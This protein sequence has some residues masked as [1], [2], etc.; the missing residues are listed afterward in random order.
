MFKTTVEKIIKFCNGKLVFKSALE[1]NVQFNLHISVDSRNV[2]SGDVFVC[3]KGDRVDGHDFIKDVL[4]N[5]P[6]VVIVQKKVDTVFENSKTIFIKVKD[7]HDAL[8]DLAAEM[9]AG[10]NNILISGSAGKT[11]TKQILN[12][13]LPN[14]Y[15]TFK[16]YNTPI[17]IP[18]AL[19]NIP[20][21]S[22]WIISELSA[23]Y[24]G[25]IEKTLK[26]FSDVKAAIL[27]SIGASHTEYFS[28]LEEIMRTK[29]QIFLNIEN[30]YT[31]F[32]NGHMGGLEKDLLEIHP[33]IKLYGFDEGFEI[34][35]KR[36]KTDSFGTTF[37]IFNNGKDIGEFCIRAFGDHFVLDATA[38]IVLTKELVGDIEYE[39][40]R[41]NLLNFKPE[42]GRGGIIELENDSVCIDESYNANP[43]SMKMCLEAFK[44]FNSN[45][46][47]LIL[48]DMLEL[49]VISKDEHKKL[50]MIANS[51]NAD[52]V[53]YVGDHFED[54][55]KGYL[56]K[57]QLHAINDVKML[58]KIVYPWI[59]NNCAVFVK[60]SNGIGL[61]QFVSDLE[62]MQRK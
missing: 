22:R 18:I 39:T 29:S 13:L 11:T 44:S 53:Y 32:A 54:F 38:S 24:R 28:S 35:I 40:I 6:R 12:C 47:V 36:V 51:V 21:D 9:S 10:R 37:S 20:D 48:G 8:I 4:K 26:C 27:T 43:L 1:N 59:K 23:S 30:P 7:T 14:S 58:K 5:F 17:G 57:S 2:L 25:E 33:N 62:K 49:G 34:Y 46:K 42:K 61:S 3:L 45:K 52:A 16:N 56:R 15:A 31:K 19:S 60:A 55:S 50:G 41:K